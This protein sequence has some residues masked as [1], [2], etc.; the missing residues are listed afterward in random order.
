MPLIYLHKILVR[1]NYSFAE[2]QIFSF[3]QPNDI[4]LFTNDFILYQK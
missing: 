4:G 2:R 3:R 1:E